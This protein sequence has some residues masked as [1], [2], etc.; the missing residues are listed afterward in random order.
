[1]ND[2]SKTNVE[3]VS[4]FL[5]QMAEAST[6]EVMNVC[7]FPLSL[8]NTMF[9]RFTSLPTCSIGSW[10][11]FEEIFH[12]HLYIGVHKQDYLILHQVIKGVM[13]T[14]LILSNTLETLRIDVFIDDL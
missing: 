5:A 14:P 10:V 2:D 11:E 3:H 6:M 7:Y 13:S 1:M 9:A 4:M 12:E 8:T